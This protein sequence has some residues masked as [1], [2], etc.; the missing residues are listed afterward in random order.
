MKYANN[1]S[2]IGVRIPEEIKRR[3]DK[4]CDSKGLK[5]SYLLSRIIEEKL[6]E[7]EEDEADLRLADQRIEDERIS[8]EEF[9]RYIEKRN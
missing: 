2:T 6:M 3:F 9:N 8:L 5:K 7:F 4:Y 1:N